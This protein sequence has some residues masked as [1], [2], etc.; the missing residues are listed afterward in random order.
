MGDPAEQ[1]T[2]TARRLL[3]VGC[4]SGIGAATGPRG[5]LA[6]LDIAIGPPRSPA[7]EIGALAAI[8]VDATDPDALAAVVDRGISALGGLDTVWSN[9]GVQTA[10][11]VLQASV[12]DL[13]RCYAANLRSH[14]VVAQRPL[15]GPSASA[16]R[17]R[18][19][20]GARPHAART[21]A[22]L[23]VGEQWTANRLGASRRLARVDLRSCRRPDTGCSTRDV[24]Q[25]G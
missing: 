15:P 3:I 19:R 14:F 18:G 1:K 9:V 25:L 12:A 17:A 2:N 13:H 10:R 24:A 22:S 8:E 16:S 20:L 5:Q 7:A 6:L 21:L 11:T 23:E 4:A